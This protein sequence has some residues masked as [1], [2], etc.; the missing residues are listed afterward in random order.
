[1]SPRKPP[2]ES[3]HTLW[4]HVVSVPTSEPDFEQRVS[5]KER[6][7]YHISPSSQV[8]SAFAL[9]A[10]HL[11]SSFVTLRGCKWE[12][13]SSRQVTLE[14]QDTLMIGGFRSLKAK[15]S[16]RANPREGSLGQAPRPGS[17]D[18]LLATRGEPLL[19][20]RHLTDPFPARWRLILWGANCYA[21]FTATGRRLAW[22]RHS[23]N[24][25]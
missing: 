19:H 18:L 23:I 3:L 17:T 22:S 4:V 11:E 14:P 8:S 7:C 10:L 1:M 9:F 16:A 24:T 20:T 25:C 21:H 15:Q 2:S 12:Q 6:S 13:F 5:T